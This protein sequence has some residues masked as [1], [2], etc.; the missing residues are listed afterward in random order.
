MYVT[1]SDYKLGAGMASDLVNTSP[2]VRRRTGEVLSSP[3]ALGRFLTDHGMEA[4]GAAHERELADED[5][6]QVHAL[7]QEIRDVLELATPAE[8]VGAA[9]ALV[10]R[11]GTGPT[12]CRDSAERWQWCVAV[13]SDA[14]V[15]DRMAAVIGTGLLGTLQ[16]LN[17][18]R[19][20]PCSSPDCDGFFVDTSKAG[21]RRYCTPE[22]CGNRLNVAGHRAR[23][24]T[25]PPEDRT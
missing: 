5:V 9:T 6:Q 18:D 14:S 20:R 16:A 23:R 19:F 7:R 12:L 25:G 10:R 1:F 2:R 3:T 21:R 17:H 24:R 22:V 4:H 8:L 13:S 15:A 11:A